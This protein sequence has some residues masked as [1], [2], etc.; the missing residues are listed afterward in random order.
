MYK[1]DI[2][3][4]TTVSTGFAVIDSLFIVAPINYGLYVFGPRF[5]KQYL[6]SFLDSQSSL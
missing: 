6:V 3:E 2:C 1:H 4:S 5:V